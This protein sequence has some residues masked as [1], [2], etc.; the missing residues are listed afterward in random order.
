MSLRI[1]AGRYKGRKIT[2][3]S[4][5]GYRPAMDKVRQALFSMLES[6]G[7]EWEGIRV[8]DL[9]AGSGSLG[10]EALSRGAGEVIFVE[11]SPKA[12]R[13]LG[14]TLTSLQ[15]PGEQWALVTKKVDRYLGHPPKEPFDLVFVDPPYGQGLLLPTLKGLLSGNWL[16]ASA[17]VAAEVEASIDVDDVPDFDQ[18]VNRTYGQTR[19]VIWTAPNPRLQSTREPSTP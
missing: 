19:I 6:R 15:V 8:M 18:I 13:A 3:V 9:F 14:E 16:T 7:V 10:L 4:G 2:T 12:I 11:N 17:C 1:A 5:P